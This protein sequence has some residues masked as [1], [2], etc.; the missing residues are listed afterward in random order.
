MDYRGELML[1]FKF[2]GKNF[3]GPK[4]TFI[5]EIGDRCAQGAI[6]EV[7]QADFSVVN[8]LNETARGVGGF[9]STGK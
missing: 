2:I 7:I 6:E 9:G 1:K 8:E 5:Y 3:F 4:P